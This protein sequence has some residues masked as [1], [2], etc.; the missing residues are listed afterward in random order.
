[1]LSIEEK[2]KVS[3]LQSISCDFKNKDTIEYLMNDQSQIFELIDRK[4]FRIY[5]R[6]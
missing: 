5:L 6:K 1:M 2:K 4:K 3:M